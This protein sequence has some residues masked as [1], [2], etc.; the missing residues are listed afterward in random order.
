MRPT[1]TLALV[2]CLIVSPVRALAQD[3][4]GTVAPGPITRSLT[5]EAARLAATPQPAPAQPSPAPADGRAAPVE[6]KWSELAPIV[7]NQHV[8]I[9][10][11]DGRIVRGEALAVRDAELLVQTK[12]DP[13][14]GTRVARESIKGV[15]VKQTRGSGWRTFGTVVGV[16]GGL[17]LTGYAAWATDSAAVGWTVFLG[18]TTAL[19]VVGYQLGKQGDTRTTRITILP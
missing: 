8:E 13:P 4:A 2:A 11:A 9:A 1:L 19:G 16:I 5:R 12:G 17:W 3:Y 18:G 6:M 7:V 10:L 15:T 14:G